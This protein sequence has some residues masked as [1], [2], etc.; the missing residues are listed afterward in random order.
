MERL[1]K[2]TF[3]RMDLQQKGYITRKEYIDLKSNTLGEELAV[4]LFDAMDME[5]KGKVQ[6]IR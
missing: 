2:E 5:R 4:A 6:V 1:G 3:G